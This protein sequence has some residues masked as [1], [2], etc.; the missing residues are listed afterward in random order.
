MAVLNR[1]RLAQ[2]KKSKRNERKV[3]EYHST[4]SVSRKVVKENEDSASILLQLAAGSEDILVFE[5]NVGDHNCFEY[6]H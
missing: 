3:N 5:E 2:E 4:V 6:S 1:K